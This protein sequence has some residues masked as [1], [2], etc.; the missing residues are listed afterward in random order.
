MVRCSVSP[1][2]YLTKYISAPGFSSSSSSMR[3]RR[4]TVPSKRASSSSSDESDDETEE[5]DEQEVSSW[6]VS[7]PLVFA[8]D[9]LGWVSSKRLV[10]V[11]W[12]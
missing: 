9:F 11:R 12:M 1:S 4:S 6:G 10:R 5:F 2:S 8:A 7:R 3:S